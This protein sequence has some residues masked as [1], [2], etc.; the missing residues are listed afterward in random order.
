MQEQFQ[1]A[2]SEVVQSI[3]NSMLELDIYPSSSITPQDVGADGI[4]AS[5]ECTGVWKG[6]VALSC[7]PKIA[8]LAASIMLGKQLP[9]VN[10]EDSKDAV[11]E[12]A[13]VVAGNVKSM[14]PGDCQLSSP[15]VFEGKNNVLE[16]R[17]GK[18]LTQMS[19]NCKTQPVIVTVYEYH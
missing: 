13:N 1:Y 16:H 6:V 14:L 19:F 17:Y 4:I 11:I 3:W 8:A 7:S 15:V 18:I 2:L 10:F 12:L 9:D 5:I